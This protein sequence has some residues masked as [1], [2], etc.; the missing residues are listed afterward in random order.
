MESPTTTAGA[1]AVEGAL[2]PARVRRRFPALR[3]M[4][5][6]RPVAYLD[7]P[8]GSQ[9]PDMVIEAMAGYLRRSNA[10]LGGAFATSRATDAVVEAARVA[11]AELTGSTPEEIAFGPNM[12]TLNYLLAHAFAR[13]L[14]SGD[15]IVVT[16]LD[17]DANVAPWLQVA[18]D[19]DLVVRHARI[20]AGDG[21]LDLDHLESLLTGR[22]RVVATCLASNALGTVPDVRRVA[23]AA[24]RAGALMWADGVHL[25]PHRRPDRDATGADVLLFSPYKVFGPHLGVAVIRR[26]LAV[27]WP[28]DR[29]RPA[30]EWPPGHRFETGTQSHEAIAGL[31]AAVDYLASLGEGLTRPERLAS[32]Y[33]RIRAYEERLA[34]RALDRLAAVP[35]CTVYGITDPARLAERTPTFAF[36]LARRTPRQVAEALAATGVY[37]WDGDYYALAPMRALGLSDGGAVRAGFLHYNTLEEADR[38]GDELEVI[39]R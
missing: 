18:A 21:T 17:H 14:A 7:G 23:D 9:T 12:T 4:H 3:A 15:E 33:E 2:D 26:D 10:N 32:A 28:A 38:L 22:T 25:A 24:H 20:R 27:S 36:T 5:A 19:H 39:A 37:V 6:G 8:G 11:A 13:T 1:G 29:V 31:T 30:G 34:A 16:D 35:D